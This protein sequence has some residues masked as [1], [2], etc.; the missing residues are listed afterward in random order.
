MRF[1]PYCRDRTNLFCITALDMVTKGNLLVLP[2]VALLVPLLRVGQV[3]AASPDSVLAPSDHVKGMV[4]AFEA[5]KAEHGRKYERDSPEHNQ[6]F[7]LFIQRTAEVEEQ[8]ARPWRLWT[9]TVNAFT[10]RTDSEL[11]QLRGWKGVATKKRGRHSAVA[12]NSV[13]GSGTFLRQR[14]KG[15]QVPKA[16]MN[17]TKLESSSQVKDQGGCGSCWAEAT[18]NVLDAHSEIYNKGRKF[19]VQELVNCVPNPHKCGGP[20][21]CGGATVELALHWVLNHG[22]AD[23]DE[24]PYAAEDGVCRKTASAALQLPAHA[25]EDDHLDQ[26][27]A[28]GVHHATFGDLA[29]S[30]GMQGWE[31]LPENAYEPL[32]RAVV[33]QG[34]V[35]VSLAASGWFSYAGGIYDSCLKDAVI[36]HAVTLTGFGEDEKAGQLFWL[37]KNSW[38]SSWGEKGYIR[39]LRTDGEDEFCGVDHQPEVG[40]GCDGGPKEVRVCGMCGILYDSAL[41]HFT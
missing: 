7:A 34:P 24:E 14:G 32:L 30:F 37:I 2:W 15:R 4:N 40:T 21:G 28:P 36:D 6:R 38:G 8:N 17:W 27:T 29:L 35:A 10:D 19:S 41:P 25:A 11:A 9:A 3:V 22:L 20:G 18:V 1:F 12:T 31:R 33:E 5:F 39:L 13:V 26:I 16:F 23:E